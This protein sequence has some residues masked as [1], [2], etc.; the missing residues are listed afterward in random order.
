[1]RWLRLCLCLTSA[2]A[3][4]V[5][6]Q[7]A[8]ASPAQGTMII[9]VGAEATQPV[10]IVSTAKANQDLSQLLFARLAHLNKG[11]STRDERSFTPE[12]A[13]SWS[14]RDPLTLVFELDPRARWH[15]G[16]PVTA[17]D[18][19]WTLDLARDSTVSGTY[20]LLLRDIAS[21]TAETDRRVVVRFRRPYAEQLYDAVW[22]VAPLPS[23]LLDTIPKERFSS[24]AFITA[25]IGSGPFR[26]LR[27]DPGRQI[28]LAANRD[29]FLGRPQ[30][31]RIVIVIARDAEA[32]LNQVLSGQAD[33]LETVMLLNNVGRVVNNASLKLI[34]V[35]SYSTTYL[36]FNQRAPDDRSKP[37]PILS[38]PV[39][40]RAIAAAIDRNSLIR[41]QFGPYAAVV[42]GPVGQASWVRRF[43]SRGQ[44]FDPALARRLLDQQGWREVQGTGIREKNGQPLTLRL[45]YP[46]SSIPRVVTAPILQEMLRQV[47]VRLELVRLDGPVW[48]ERRNKG[49]F[50]L[51]FSSATLDPTPSGLVQSWTCA[52]RAASNVGQWCNPTFDS[53]LAAANAAPGTG[54][55]V[56]RAAF[57]ELDRDQ[58]AVFLFSSFNTVILNERYRN[59]SFP[60]ESPWSD[61]WR[62]RIDPSRRLERD[63]PTPR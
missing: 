51:D 57:A 62:F 59:V 16:Q 52:G 50:D 9:V 8:P 58:P 45:N 44:S 63:G 28:E 5:A 37:H 34:T 11:G 10:P 18:V 24:A 25:P 15:D 12:L 27:R 36:L 55:A 26:F 29:Y 43:T 30:L 41:S 14:R 56:W 6:A 53:L 19:V 33:L 61:L 4:S 32:Q 2:A 20:A 38:D 22:Q 21:V 31:D 7:A 54:D 3:S 60:P 42:N 35:P 23:H 17:K 40:R 39:V 13:K 1:M 49:Q 46:G 47:G 48:A